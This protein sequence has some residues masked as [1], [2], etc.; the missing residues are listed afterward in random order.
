[1][2]AI[3]QN[4]TQAKLHLYGGGRLV[5]AMRNLSKE[6]GLDDCVT[7]HGVVPFFELPEILKK[8]DLGIVPTKDSVF[9]DEALSMKSLEYM[10]LGIPIVIS[11]TTAH[12]YYYNDSMVRFFRPRD[13]NDLANAII[14]LYRDENMRNRLTDNANEFLERHSWSLAKQDYYNT[15][16]SLLAVKPQKADK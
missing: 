10:T 9:S 7:F 15:I 4:I 12:S 16:D 1:M 14:S 8:A 5:N 3:R 11:K 13:H 2:P 6:L